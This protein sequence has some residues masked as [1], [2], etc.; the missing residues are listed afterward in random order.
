MR[1]ILSEQVQTGEIDIATLEIELDN[2]DEIPQLRRGLQYI[3]RQEPLRNKIF[4]LLWEIIPADVDGKNGRKGMDLWQILILGT[5]RLN[6]NWDYDKLQEIANNHHTLRQMLGHGMLDF[7]TRYPRQTLND[8]ISWFTP[9]VL[10]KINHMVVNAGMNLLE[11]EAAIEKSAAR[12]DSFVLETDVHFP[13]DLNLLLDAVRKALQLSHK[14]AQRFFIDGWYQTPYNIRTLKSLFRNAQKQR[15]K[16]NDSAACIQATQRY[17]DEAANR[18]FQAEI[19]A[20]TMQNDPLYGGVGD[21]I[22]RFVDHGKRQID[23]ISRRCFNDE[24]IPHE[25]KVFSLFE[26]H[27]E[28]ISKGKAGIPQKLG[29]RVCIVES[30][31]GFTLHSWV[32]FGNVLRGMIYSFIQT[33]RES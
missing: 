2:R 18:L 17:I 14:M 31:T 8:N 4:K 3:Y 27:T 19:V 20:G 28:W 32:F 29:L 13:T 12:C 1:K 21:E 5:L 7:E 30:S 25:E 22:Q 33:R 24:T 11:K 9:A 6:C 26:E 15:D 16:D 10:D 23:Q